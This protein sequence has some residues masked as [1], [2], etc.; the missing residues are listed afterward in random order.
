MRVE[1][2]GIDSIMHVVKRGTR[3]LDIVRDIKDKERFIKTL[4]LFNDEYSDAN[5]SRLSSLSLYERPEHWPEPKPLVRILGWTLLSN[6]FHILMQEI[7]EGGIAKFMQRICGSMSL[8]YNYKYK[9]K[10][11]LFQGSYKG[12]TITKESHFLYLPFYI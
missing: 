1:P 8:A 9:E 7:K 11:S 5:L 12:K 2:H 3:G 4:F 6:H 10:G